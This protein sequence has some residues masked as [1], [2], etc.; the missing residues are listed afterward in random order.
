MPTSAFGLLFLGLVGITWLI[1]AW[2]SLQPLQG[3]PA[4][5]PKVPR[6]L[7]PRT[8][9]DC[10]VCCPSVPCP[11]L[12]APVRAPVRP[13]CEIKSRRGAPKRISTQGFACPMPTCP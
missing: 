8:P 6:L 13:W 12:P 9:L 1:I 7:K 3:R 5:P 4:V 2:R 11:A 10:P